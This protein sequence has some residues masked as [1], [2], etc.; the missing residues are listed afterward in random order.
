MKRKI[1]LL[2]LC[3]ALIAIQAQAA[4]VTFFGEDRGL[5]EFTPLASHPNSDAARNAFLANLVGTGTET[6]ES[7]ASGTGTP[8]GISFPGAGTATLGGSGNVSV[9]AAGSTN[10]V[11]RY[12]ISGTH[13]WEAGS[14]YSAFS[15]DF[16][17][18][19]AAFGFYGVDIGDFNGQIKLTLTNGGGTTNITVPNSTNVPGGGVLYFG[20]YDT[21]TQYSRIEF[22]NTNPGGGDYFGFDDMTIG[23]LE[24]V[25][26]KST[27]PEPGTLLLL[28]SGL[29]GLAA[30]RRKR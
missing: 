21:A 27:V 29:V 17:S 30:Y 18:P 2:T 16:S 28:G 8:L 15:I 1:A 23:S 11:G 9:V 14:S 20:F 25:H 10:G 6:F 19:I 22:L 13:F 24:Q 12:A 3:L 26:P 7:Y 5:G 4:P